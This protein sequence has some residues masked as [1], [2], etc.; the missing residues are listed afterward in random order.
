MG[1]DGCPKIN[2]FMLQHKP[3]GCHEE[4]MITYRRSAMPKSPAGEVPFSW[5]CWCILQQKTQTRW[6]LCMFL[7]MCPHHEAL[8][9]AP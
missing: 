5:N 2:R 4:P 7:Q 8:S 3:Q 6:Y 9:A 1:M